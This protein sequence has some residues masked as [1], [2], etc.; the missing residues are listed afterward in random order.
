MRRPVLIPLILLIIATI[1]A[2]AFL[3]VFFVGDHYSLHLEQ[4]D[5]FRFVILD[6]QKEGEK[7]DT[8][9]AKVRAFHTQKQWQKTKGTV[10]LHIGSNHSPE[11]EYGDLIEADCDFYRIRNYPNS[12]FDYAEYAKHNRLYHNVYVSQWSLLSKHEG[13]IIVE[14]SKKCNKSLKERLKTSS[15]D[16]ENAALAA[17]IL[18]GDKKEL[19]KNL[20]ESFSVSGLAHILCVSGLHIGLIIAIFDIL[21][22]GLHLLGMKGFYLRKILL[23]LTAWVIAFIVG[24]TP[25][26]MRV[27]AMLGLIIVSDVFFYKSDSFNILLCTAFIFLLFDPLLLF[28]LSFQLSFLAVLGILVCMPVLKEDINKH[29]N[30]YLKKPFSYAATT[31]SAQTFVLPIIVYRFN[32][33]PLMFLLSNLIVV[34]FLSIVLF[35]IILCLVFAD[36]PIIGNMVSSVLDMELTALRTVATISEKITNDILF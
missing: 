18:L 11:L 16:K 36:T 3:P 28:N 12:T 20:K 24:C 10:L 32:T 21:F 31:L 19:D 29:I 30:R 17:S 6:K 25:S 27:A 22:R 5:K 9:K 4:S 1:A 13:N 14:Y 26:A 8:Y 23:V 35:S 33:L 34:P 2:D 7:Y 15:L